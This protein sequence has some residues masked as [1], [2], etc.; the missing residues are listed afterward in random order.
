[1]VSVYFNFWGGGVNSWVKPFDVGLQVLFFKKKDSLFVLV[2]NRENFK[3]V[4]AG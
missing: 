1:M 4:G 2:G 3:Q